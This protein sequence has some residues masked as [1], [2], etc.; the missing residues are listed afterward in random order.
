NY[1]W[2]HWM[3]SVEMNL[4]EGG[5]G[6][7]P[8]GDPLAWANRFDVGVRMRWN[9]SEFVYAKQKRHQADANIQQVHLSYQD[10]KAKLTLGVQ[11]ARD[12]IHS[13]R[14][15]LQLA[16]RHIDFAEESYK[17]SSQRLKDNVRGRSTSEVLLA[18][19][20]LGGARLEYVQ[21]VRDLDKA[22]LRLF[23]LV[24]ALE[25]DGEQ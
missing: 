16:E 19:R 3:P 9:L 12:S 2:S 21:A 24:G 10:L 5:F 18:M 4:I 13:G 7:S 23:V 15:Q 25:A 14:E 17:L 1:G 11:E 20:A 6:A 22:N 8:A